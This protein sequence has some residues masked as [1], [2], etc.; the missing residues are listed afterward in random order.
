MRR[1]LRESFDDMAVCRN[2]AAIVDKKAG[3]DKL[4]KRR[5]CACL[6]DLEPKATMLGARLSKASSRFMLRAV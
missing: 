5:R 6:R 2:Y 3:A 4:R 1:K